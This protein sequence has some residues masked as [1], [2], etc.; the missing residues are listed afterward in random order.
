VSPRFH[1]A[2]G[3]IGRHQASKLSG[4]LFRS[5]KEVVWIAGTN[6]SKNTLSPSSG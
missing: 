6:F 2:N 3:G 4:Y 1:E 5:G